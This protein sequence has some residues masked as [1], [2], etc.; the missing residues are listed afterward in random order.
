MS[1]AELRQRGPHVAGGRHSPCDSLATV[2]TTG[3]DAADPPVRRLAQLLGVGLR[4]FDVRKLRRPVL[5][6]ADTVIAIVNKGLLDCAVADSGIAWCRGSGPRCGPRR[7]PA[8][9]RNLVKY[10]GQPL[11]PRLVADDAVQD[12]P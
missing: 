8:S 5:A 4:V 12:G 11:V 9:I 7:R 1:L 2:P 3:E 6:P 10:M